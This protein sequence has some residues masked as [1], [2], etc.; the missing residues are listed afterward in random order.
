MG[1]RQRLVL[2]VFGEVEFGTCSRNSSAVGSEYHVIYSLV[3]GFFPLDVGGRVQ[4][5]LASS[6]DT[7]ILR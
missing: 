7:G 5:C 4:R 3:E 6:P 2:F 1:N